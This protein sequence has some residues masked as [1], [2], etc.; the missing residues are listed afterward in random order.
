MLYAFLYQYLS[1]TMQENIRNISFIQM[2]TFD[3]T[4]FGEHSQG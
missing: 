3:D 2:N 4:P 1:L